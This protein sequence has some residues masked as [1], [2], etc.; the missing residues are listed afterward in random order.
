MGIATGMKDLTRNIAESRRGRKQRIGEIRQEVNENRG[1]TADMLDAFSHQRNE[2]SRQVRQDLATGKARRKTEIAGILSEAQK[3][4]KRADTTR[5]ETSARLRTRLTRTTAKTRDEVVELKGQA[6][7]LVN[8]FHT[9]RGETGAQMKNSLARNN[10]DRKTG[11]KKMLG[12]LNSS[13]DGV[14]ADL[15]EAR[16]AWRG[17]P[18][19]SR[20]GAITHTE[21]LF[22]EKAKT[23]TTGPDVEKKTFK[24]KDLSSKKKAAISI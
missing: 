16:A 13:R 2:A 3:S 9:T 19:T 8:D 11:V 5:K 14:K 24:V 7:T 6:R 12:N 10:S 17:E 18:S 22:P 20:Y 21:L 23:G 15:K 1:E 4:L